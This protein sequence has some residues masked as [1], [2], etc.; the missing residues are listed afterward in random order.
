M[1]PFDTVWTVIA[2]LAGVVFLGSKPEDEVA[3]GEE[4]QG[5]EE[6]VPF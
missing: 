3:A 2:L 6:D 5:W 4:P 1:D